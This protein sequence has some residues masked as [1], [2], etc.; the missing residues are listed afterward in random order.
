MSV[1]II[2][3]EMD[4]NGCS[5]FVSSL[6]PIEFILD[7]TVACFSQQILDNLSHRKPHFNRFQIFANF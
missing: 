4:K 6:V 2:E 3:V 5:Y 7:F 1:R